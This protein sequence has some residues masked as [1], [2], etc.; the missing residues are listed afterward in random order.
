M[1]RPAAHSFSTMWTAHD[2]TATRA[3]TFDGTQ[4]SADHVQRSF[5]SALSGTY[6]NVQAAARLTHGL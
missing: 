1:H 2:A 5:L 4:V 6:A 3:L